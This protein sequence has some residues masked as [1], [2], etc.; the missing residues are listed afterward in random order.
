M[1]SQE[2]S[3]KDLTDRFKS[4]YDL[5]YYLHN[6]R[7]LR[8]QLNSDRS[9]SFSSL[10][11]TRRKILHLALMVQLI[12][13]DK[14]HFTVDQVPEVQIPRYRELKLKNILK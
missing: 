3:L 1:V 10:V 13:G 5:H 6:K 7:K 14:N 2:I 12:E 11:S 4:V 9:S 8:F